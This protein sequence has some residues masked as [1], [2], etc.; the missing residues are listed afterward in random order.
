MTS[1]GPGGGDI[2]WRPSADIVENST[3]TKFLRANGLAGFD[4]LLAKSAAEPAWYWD[5]VIRY[6]G[7]RFQRP[8][9]TVMDLS[10]GNPWAK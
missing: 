7:I 3:L 10:E 6:F 4:A 5:V 9:E 8:Y 2:V 1:P